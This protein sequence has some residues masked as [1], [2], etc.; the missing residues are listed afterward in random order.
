MRCPSNLDHCR[1]HGRARDRRLRTREPV[2][3]QVPA[4]HVAD[5]IVNLG[6]LHLNFDVKT[7]RFGAGTSSRMG[8]VQDRCFAAP[9]LMANSA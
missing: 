1:R 9:A 4:V 8:K 6:T 5:R 7:G 2:L 3:H